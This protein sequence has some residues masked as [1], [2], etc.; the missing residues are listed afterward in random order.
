ME[1]SVAWILAAVLRHRRSI[2]GF[3]AVGLFLA[4]IVILVRGPAYSVAFSFVPESG[5]EQGRGGLAG[6]AGQLGI[7]A[8]VLGESSQPPQFYADLLETREVLGPLA[9]DSFTVDSGERGRVPLADFLGIHGGTGPV[10]TELTFETLRDKVVSTSV[11][12]RSTGVIN[13]AV[14]TKSPTVS[15]AIAQRLI[16]G[17]NRFNR[18]MRQSRAT[19]ERKFVES[20]LQEAHASLRAAEDDLQG[21]LQRNRE[22]A[23]SPQLVFDQDRLQRAVSLQ[24]QVVMGLA[25][26]YEDARIREVRDTPVITLIE[27]PILPALPAPRRRVSTLL[28]GTGF[29]FGLGTMLALAIE[30][31]RRQRANEPDEQSYLTLADEWRRVR[32]T[33]KVH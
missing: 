32:G 21:F 27:R 31:W 17:L 33:G 3:S 10:R 8:G 4:L 9:S 15:L 6:I 29:A 25:Q 16:D 5:Q 20:R 30:G 23:K 14:R 13:V 26:Q 18:E 24:Q 22:F 19:E 11:A 2:L 7:P 28:L 1:V 12:A